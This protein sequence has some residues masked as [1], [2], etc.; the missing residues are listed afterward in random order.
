MYQ[1]T[2]P[3]TTKSARIHPFFPA[4]GRMK[5]ATS[6]RIAGR[7][8]GA[9][10]PTMASPALHPMSKGSQTIL[11]PGKPRK[12]D[13]H[14]DCNSEQEY[15]P[16]PLERTNCDQHSRRRG[17]NDCQEKRNVKRHRRCVPNFS[18]IRCTSFYIDALRDFL[19]VTLRI[20]HGHRDCI[21]SGSRVCV[22]D[23]LHSRSE[24]HT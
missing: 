14:C 15:N 19:D 13:H 16:V 9:M 22:L 8:Y 24:E 17:S 11:H 20:S 2:T 18:I 4:L 6:T 21:E 7:M 5:S 10:M 23:A 3:P 1:S 12:R